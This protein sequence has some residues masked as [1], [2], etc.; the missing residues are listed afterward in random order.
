MTPEERRKWMEDRLAKMS[1]EERE[2]FQARM[3]ERQGDRG[4]FG[5]G[6]SRQ[7][8]GGANAS[9]EAGGRRDAS[10]GI[11]GSI[12][13]GAAHT[14]GATTIDVLFAPLPTV[15]R[16]ERAWIYV[17]KKLK[18]VNLRTGISDGTYTEILSGEVQQGQ[19]VVVSMTTGLEPQT[20]PGQQQGGSQNPLMGPQRGGRGGPGGGGGGGR[21]RG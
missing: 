11:A 8:T 21:G 10:R 19:E 17:D 6:D 9:A 18:P 4:G 12:T 2:R 7:T 13:P 3:R 5:G 16:R 20:R 14:S 1:P 15:E